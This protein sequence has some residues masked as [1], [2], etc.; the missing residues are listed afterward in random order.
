MLSALSLITVNART[1]TGMRRLSFIPK[2]Q[3]GR[4]RW[5][6]SSGRKLTAALIPLTRSRC[7]RCLLHHVSS[8]LPPTPEAA[9]AKR[10]CRI[11]IIKQ[12][13][14]TR[15]SIRPNPPSRLI[16][17]HIHRIITTMMASPIACANMNITRELYGCRSRKQKPR[18]GT[19]SAL[20]S[21]PAS[22]P[23]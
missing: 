12:H 22:Q 23:N 19:K 6:T 11:M 16:D 14:I 9:K 10:C 21:I 1:F 17:R 13:S 2:S 5:R 20:N 4:H 8:R 15:R 7:A 3:R 18:M